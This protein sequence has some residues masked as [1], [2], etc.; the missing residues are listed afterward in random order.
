MASGPVYKSMKIEGKQIRL[1]FDL[2][3]G[4]LVKA[5]DSAPL[6]NFTIA[7]ADRKFYPAKAAIDGETVLVWSDQVPNPVAV[8]YAWASTAPDCDFFSSNAFNLTRL[9][10]G[11]FRTDDWPAQLPAEKK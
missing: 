7:G 11:T 9:P 2:D 8:R 6:H 3:G 4:R 5:T 10:A 1:R